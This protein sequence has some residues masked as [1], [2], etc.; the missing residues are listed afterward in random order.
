MTAPI[1]AYVVARRRGPTH[2]QRA[3]RAIA[4]SPCYGGG[5]GGL[6]VIGLFSDTPEPKC[7][8]AS[9]GERILVVNRSG[10][11]FKRDRAMSFLR[12]G[13]YVAH[14]GPQEAAL[15]PAQVGTYLGYGLHEFGGRSGVATPG[16]LVVRPKCNMHPGGLSEPFSR[17]F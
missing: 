10:A 11:F 7:L 5:N 9:P 14:I 4:A 16:V 1:K 12:L 17:C 2:V 6:A 13:D 3:P 8:L 15:F